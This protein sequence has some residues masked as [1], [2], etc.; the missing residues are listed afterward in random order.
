MWRESFSYRLVQLILVIYPDLTRMFWGNVPSYAVRYLVLHR[1]IWRA[2][3][4]K[5]IQS[6]FSRTVCTRSDPCLGVFA[7][8]YIFN[9]F[10]LRPNEGFSCHISIS[11]SNPGPVRLQTS[12]FENASCRL[13]RG[14]TPVRTLLPSFGCDI[15]LLISC[16]FFSNLLRVQDWELLNV[17]Q[18]AYKHL[19][20]LQYDLLQMFMYKRCQNSMHQV[21]VD[22]R[23]TKL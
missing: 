10:R 15:G 12:S 23:V 6:V 21:L 7:W 9:V 17:C 20:I 16:R 18:Q 1:S 22:S 8:A 5:C 19:K 2:C 4:T 13:I 14:S 11:T 3:R